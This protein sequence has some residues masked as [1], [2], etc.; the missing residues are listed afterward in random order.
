MF[1]MQDT[2]FPLVIEKV[3]R[4]GGKVGSL[5]SHFSSGCK[6]TLQEPLSILRIYGKVVSLKVSPASN[7][8]SF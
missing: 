7:F 5:G 2:A 6:T 8:I 4:E 3:V 1:G